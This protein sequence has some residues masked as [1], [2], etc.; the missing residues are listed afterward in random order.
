LWRGWGLE[1]SYVLGHSL[2]EYVA[3]T[4][5]GVFTLED[6]LPLVALRGRLMQQLPSGG[7][8]VAVFAPEAQVA[9]AVAR[10]AAVAIAAVNAPNNIVISGAGDAVAAV[11]AQLAAHGVQYKDLD[12]SHAFHSPLMDP[13]LDTFE[14]AVAAVS[15]RAPS[16][17]L[18]SNLTGELLTPAD[19]I[20]PA[21]WRRQLRESVRFGASIERLVDRGV[22]TFVEV[23][24]HPTLC[25]LGAQSAPGALRWLPSVRRHV[26]AWQTLT[27]S[28]GELFKSGEAVDWRCWAEPYAGRR[29]GVAP[30]YP[31]QRERHWFSDEV[32]PQASSPAPLA[33]PAGR[34]ARHPL[35]GAALQS[36]LLPGWAFHTTLS[37]EQPGYLVDYQVEGR[38][39]VPAAL[40]IEMMTAALEEGPR[41]PQARLTDVVFASSFTLAADAAVICQVL[42]STPRHGVAEIRIVSASPGDD[43][44]RWV[45]QAT[46]NAHLTAPSPQD[47]VSGDERGPLRSLSQLQ[48]SIVDPMVMATFH[49]RLLEQGL[50]YGPAFS[51]LDAIWTGRD[52]A[53][54]HAQLPADAAADV[55]AYRVH[56]CLLDTALQL[57]ESLAPDDGHDGVLLPSGLD[58]VRVVGALGA[59]CWI[60]AALREVANANAN[61]NGHASTNDN[62]SVNDNALVADLTVFDE[63]GAVRAELRG[64]RGRR[65]R[66]VR[67]RH[68]D[69]APVH[70]VQWVSVPAPGALER[71][72][73]GPWLI[74]ED[75]SG[76]GAALARA[77]ESRGGRCVRVR[78]G[79]DAASGNA[80]SV[81]PASVA[82][83][84]RVA[85]VMAP[86]GAPLGIVHC[87]SCDDAR[88]H[89]TPMEDSSAFVLDMV[90]AR[91]ELLHLGLGAHAPFG[92]R[93]VTRGAAGPVQETARDAEAGAA[94]SGM[95]QVVQAEYPA[96]SCRTVDLDPRMSLE[97]ERVD[98]L[99]LLFGACRDDRLAVR[100]HEVLAPR[101]KRLTDRPTDDRRSLP[102]TEAYRVAIRRRGTLD[103]LHYV[104]AVRRA[105]QRHEVEVRVHATGLNC[106][107]V[108]NVLG[109]YPG[110]AGD[111]GEEFAGIVLRVGDGVTHVC[112][113]DE[114]IGIGSGTFASHVT[115]PAAGVT[116]APRSL[117][118]VEAVTIPLAFLTAEWGLSDLAALQPGERVLI[119]AA[120]GGVGQAA[121][122]LA[123]DCS[124]EI[125]A[126]AGS[127]EQR[128][129]LRAQG[130]VHVFDSRSAAFVNGI[131]AITAGQGVD[132][133]LNSLSG[134]LV[135]ASMDALR[136]GG[137]FIEIG[138]PN[139]TAPSEVASRVGGI[140]YHAFD[141]GAMLREQ[142]ET[143]QSLF[144]RVTARFDR[145]TL[146][147][148]ATRVY[149]ADEI[150]DAFRD[151]AQASQIGKV[152]ISAGGVAPL[153]SA[154]PSASGFDPTTLAA[155]H[156]GARRRLVVAY[157]CATLASVLGMRDTSLDPDAE[158]MHIGFDSL[159]AM[160]LRNRIEA[161]L[162]IV[163]PVAPL[164]DG[165]TP[166]AAA[167]VIER[168]IVDRV[169]AMAPKEDPQTWVEGEI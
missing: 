161:D 124:A 94:L 62:V 70:H 28:V 53:L 83:W 68:P 42:V 29:S 147:P 141:L 145:G 71:V 10:V 125:F 123:Q 49:A 106:R 40:L 120:A 26:G 88:S 159:M 34:R 113:G 82:D 158:L 45:T 50:V 112:P 131:R 156:P 122:R 55:A 41:W 30:T 14:Q 108:G 37:P 17:G 101:L 152:V 117:S 32:P 54:A 81:D 126:T 98:L 12:V 11:V 57:L 44:I 127:E 107:D 133:V 89:D 59:S 78:R 144:S 128:A 67:P 167:T 105:P 21:R 148:I 31:F 33:I 60:H 169:P 7:R 93:F 160:E 97:D 15:R 119:H 65:L 165:A 150:I 140:Q 22:R 76:V 63:Q 132:V 36:P 115:G 25:A 166:N 69:D 168:L 129:F 118:S 103:A 56:P 162:G 157:M 139:V 48:A 6:A 77:L 2:G 86:L 13:I 153:W 38:I 100:G 80:L 47:A 51:G 130:V 1:P 64:F 99:S 92:I 23:G 79:S 142:P 74:L 163:V 8:M 20:D 18:I 87:W 154:A 24:P 61:A 135:Q 5:A 138:T 121:V 39:V 149:A 90:A 146:R 110:H 85:A 84:R 114:V 19:A 58:A 96:L 66:G 104:P 27:Q 46:A 4:V 75:T 52:G 73:E 43:E 102:R 111:P 134:D 143:F 151:M 9:V 109:R 164:L 95:Q 35:L 155:A 136:P 3:A 116:H 16:I 91:P 137:R 72:D